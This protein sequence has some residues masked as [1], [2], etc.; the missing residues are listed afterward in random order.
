MAEALQNPAAGGTDMVCTGA[1]E[2]LPYHN[3]EVYVYVDI[4]QS[5]D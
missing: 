5:P 1:L 4:I 3:Y 2:G